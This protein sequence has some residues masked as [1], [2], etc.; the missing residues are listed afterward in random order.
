MT[1]LQ[2]TNSCNGL[3]ECHGGD[4][5]RKGLRYLMEGE[6]VLVIHKRFKLALLRLD[7]RNKLL[8]LDHPYLDLDLNLGEGVVPIH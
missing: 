4:P 7:Q 1:Y 3:N 6:K 2:I 5:L 8:A